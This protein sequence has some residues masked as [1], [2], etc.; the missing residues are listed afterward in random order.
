MFG[1]FQHGKG[2][3]GRT[4]WDAFNAVTEYFDHYEGSTRIANAIDRGR[5]FARVWN[6]AF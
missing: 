6:V 4:R 5:T 1:L 3:I 2:N